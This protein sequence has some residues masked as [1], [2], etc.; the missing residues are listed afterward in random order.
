MPMKFRYNNDTVI[1]KLYERFGPGIWTIS[2]DVRVRHLGFIQTGIVFCSRPHRKKAILLL[3]RTKGSFFLRVEALLI[4]R[5]P[6][7]N[8]RTCDF[9]Y[10]TLQYIPS[11]N[12]LQASP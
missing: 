9:H 5:F 10:L 4:H 7:R 3:V 11:R 1:L 12:N 6:I 2:A 8:R